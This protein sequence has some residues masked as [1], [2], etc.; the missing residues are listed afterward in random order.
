MYKNKISELGL[1]DASGIS[2][3]TVTK[4]IC[5]NTLSVCE[6]YIKKGTVNHVNVQSCTQYCAAYNLRCIEM[7]RD[8]NG[9]ER[10]SQYETC[11]EI[12]WRTTD[13]ICVCSK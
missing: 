7:Y 5:A 6:A 12:G 9:C 11:D 3:D 13:H 1:C 10:R 8:H 4:I 2:P